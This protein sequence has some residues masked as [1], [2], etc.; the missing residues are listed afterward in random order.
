M[1]E[2]VGLFK[3][4]D[5]LQSAVKELERTEFPRDAL[6]ILG[7]HEKLGP[8]LDRY[9]SNSFNSDELEA[10]VRSEE[11]TIGAGVLVSGTAYIGAMAAALAAG[12]VT[13]PAIIAVAAMGGA[14]GA[15]TGGILAKLLGDRFD[16]QIEDQVNKGGLMLWVR[17]P[18]QH[19]EDLACRILAD[20]G[21]EHVQIYDF[22]KSSI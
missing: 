13:V 1:R 21:A 10:P 8:D 20:Y 4:M 7:Q 15:A 18:D 5:Q 12:A 6:S 9:I 16:H 3:D 14:G 17:T 2:A 11:K 22:E 19:K